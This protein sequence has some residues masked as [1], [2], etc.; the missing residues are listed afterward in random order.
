MSSSSGSSSEV[1][2]VKVILV[3]LNDTQCDAL[4][5]ALVLE[6]SGEDPFRGVNMHT[7][8]SLKKKFLVEDG[9]G[10]R[11]LTP[12]GRAVASYLMNRHG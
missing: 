2:L 5:A 12:E 11:V 10:V 7:V 9:G 6:A 8:N 1:D 3:D 4:V